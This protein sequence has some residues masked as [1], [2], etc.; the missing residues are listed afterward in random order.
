MNTLWSVFPQPR[1][2][3]FRTPTQQIMK[4]PEVSIIPDLVET[5]HDT[6]G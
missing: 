4:T 5:Y 2:Q 1:E 3:D 6:H